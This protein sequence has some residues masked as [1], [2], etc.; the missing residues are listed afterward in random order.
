MLR[1]AAKVRVVSTIISFP[2]ALRNDFVHLSCIKTAR[3]LVVFE[4]RGFRIR[5]KGEG[6]TNLARV[7]FHF[8][9]YFFVQECLLV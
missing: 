3:F 9:L 6:Q 5:G 1:R 2:A 4:E 7:S 8:E